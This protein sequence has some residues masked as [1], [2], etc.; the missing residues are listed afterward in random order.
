[1]TDYIVSRGS[2]IPFYTSQSL[3]TNDLVIEDPYGYP[4]QDRV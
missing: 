3:I 4:V 2:F 1:M